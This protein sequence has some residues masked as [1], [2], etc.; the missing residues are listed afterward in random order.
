M[1]E[2]KLAFVGRGFLLT[3]AEQR[4]EHRFIQLPRTVLV[5]IAQSGSLGNILHAQMAQLSLTRRQPA[6]DLA[7][8]LG[9]AQL[10][11]QH[12]DHLR[13]TGKASGVPLGLVLLHGRFKLHSWNQLQNLTENTA[14][15]IQGGISLR[16]HWFLLRTQSNV[17]QVP[18]FLKHMPLGPRG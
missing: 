8:A 17:T 5:G 18:P 11:K 4:V 6:G 14:Y 15:S 3:A 16:W 13:P 12:G 2:T 7:Q 9:V 1:L 10:A